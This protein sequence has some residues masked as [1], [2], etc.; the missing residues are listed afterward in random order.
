M[1]GFLLITLA[2]ASRH[3]DLREPAERFAMSLSESPRECP[4]D[5]PALCKHIQG[6]PVAVKEIFGF[7]GGDGS[8]VDFSRVTTVA[9]PS[10][11]KLICHA[12]AK[13]ARVVMAAPQPEKVMLADNMTRAHWVS[14][15]VAAVQALP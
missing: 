4:C 2:K 7:S 14:Q 13:G 12:H 3:A 5:D 8:K 11:P 10:D 6:P 1:F 9:W 15:T